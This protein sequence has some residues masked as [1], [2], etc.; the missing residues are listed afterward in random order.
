MLVDFRLM[1]ILDMFEEQWFAEAGVVK[2]Y[3]AKPGGIPRS[4]YEAVR[5]YA[6]KDSIIAGGQ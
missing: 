1:Q 6:V 4:D 2:Q 5:Q 3:G